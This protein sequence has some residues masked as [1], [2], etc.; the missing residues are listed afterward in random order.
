MSTIT[1]DTLYNWAKDTIVNWD[2]VA[3]SFTEFVDLGTDY[4]FRALQIYST[5]DAPVIFR[6]FNPVSSSW[7]EIYVPSKG[8]SVSFGQ[9]LDNFLH[10]GSMELKYASSA[11][12][13]GFIKF[14]TW[15]AE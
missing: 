10:N 1:D 11:P 9:S 8:G 2:E 13:E 4:M 14:L 6:I 15:R 7:H 12:T 3:A 5:L